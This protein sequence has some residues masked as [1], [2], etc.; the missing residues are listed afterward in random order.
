MK[1][2]VFRQLIF[3]ELILFRKGFW[4]KIFDITMLLGTNM[5]VF[6][7]FMPQLGVGSS[8]GPFILI[9]A[10]STFGFFDII[11][12][13]GS[14]IAD[15]EGS[16]TIY[17]SL[18]LPISSRM[19]F[20]TIALNW[21]THTFLLTLP[22]FVI[23]KLFLWNSF[24]LTAI[25]YWRLIIIFT[26]VN[27]FHGFFALLITAV[28]HKINNLGRLWFRVI[29]PI[30]MFAGYF[31]SWADVQ[32]FSPLFSKIILINPLLYCVEGMRAAALGQ[33]GYL[34]FWVCVLVVWLFI[35]LSAFI[36]IRKLKRWLDCI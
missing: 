16:R 2:I 31:Y 32:K 17:Y 23:G 10:I 20:S 34:P 11:G 36:G 3:K 33:D 12:R 13:V 4:G 5:V 8:Y 30:F 9:G 19:L 28:F 21:A 35:C 18:T 27:L 25:S 14:M 29:N 15:I 24:D 6:G 1:W 22:L 7:Y 26:T